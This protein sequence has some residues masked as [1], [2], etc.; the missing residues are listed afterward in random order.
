MNLLDFKKSTI[1]Q[2]FELVKLE[3]KRWGVEVKG[4][5]IIGL[6]PLE[7]LVDVAGFYL[8]IPELSVEQV[9]EYHLF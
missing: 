2:A 7:A 6:L 4:G 8:G 1:Y 5:E 9:L 3:A